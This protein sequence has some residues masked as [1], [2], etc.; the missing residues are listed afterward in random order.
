MP[1]INPLIAW[2]YAMSPN[3]RENYY[4]WNGK[5]EECG[6]A[7]ANPISLRKLVDKREKAEAE[8]KKGT[9]NART[10]SGI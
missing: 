4:I 8:R 10:S 6:Y 3:E 1:N 5:Q 7:P 2:L 9:L